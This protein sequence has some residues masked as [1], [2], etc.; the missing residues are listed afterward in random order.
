MCYHNYV[1]ILTSG[2]VFRQRISFSQFKVNSPCTVYK[3]YWICP[4]PISPSCFLNFALGICHLAGLQTYSCLHVLYLDVSCTS[5]FNIFSPFAEH[6]KIPPGGCSVV[7]LTTRQ[8]TVNGYLHRIL[9]LR[10]RK[11]YYY[12]ITL[13]C[14]QQRESK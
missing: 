11:F 10:Q 4:L 5:K 9:C 6:Y 14:A 2:Q 7:L 13:Y 1:E 8:T 12:H 3:M